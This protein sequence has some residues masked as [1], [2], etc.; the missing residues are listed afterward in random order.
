MI[1]GSFIIANIGLP[2][3]KKEIFGDFGEVSFIDFLFDVSGGGGIRFNRL[4]I[5]HGLGKLDIQV[6]LIELDSVDMN[7]H[8]MQV[9]WLGLQYSLELY[10][11]VLNKYV[12][13]F[14]AFVVI[15][16]KSVH[17]LQ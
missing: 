12:F 13:I 15:L 17:I 8:R 14:C 6:L 5:G 3:A 11:F 16:N 1:D 4:N 10:P 2:N 7:F 9:K